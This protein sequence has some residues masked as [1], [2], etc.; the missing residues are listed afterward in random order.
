MDFSLTDERGGS[1]PRS[2]RFHF[3]NGLPTSGGGTHES[4]FRDGE[5]A[6]GRCVGEGG[7]ARVRGLHARQVRQRRGARLP[8]ARFEAAE[9]TVGN[10]YSA[11][12]VT[13]IGLPMVTGAPDRESG[14]AA[15]EP[16]APESESWA[17]VAFATDRG[18]DH[19]RYGY[20]GAGE[21]PD[22]RSAN[23]H[24]SPLISPVDR[25]LKRACVAWR[26]CRFA[27]TE[28]STA[29]ARDSLSSAIH[30]EL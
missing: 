11:A 20:G 29:P 24:E 28:F 18:R 14:S 13:G 1:D 17:P 27:H 10:V 2:Y 3:P 15:T 7:G 30:S 19:R 21:S 5:R 22:E 4:G 23:V 25:L 26:R 16:R 12:P 9:E 8:F 6:D